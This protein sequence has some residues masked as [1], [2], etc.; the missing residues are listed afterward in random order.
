[1]RSF[2]YPCQGGSTARATAACSRRGWRASRLWSLGL[3]TLCALAQAQEQEGVDGPS[4]LEPGMACE[5]MSGTIGFEQQSVFGITPAQ[6]FAEVE[7]E[8]SARLEWSLPLFDRFLQIPG[9]ESKIDVD[10]RLDRSR[11]TQS[12]GMDCTRALEAAVEVSVA[13]VDGA[14]RGTYEGQIAYLDGWASRLMPIAIAVPD[15]ALPLEL[16]PGEEPIVLMEIDRLSDHCAGLIKVLV[17][18]KEEPVEVAGWGTA[19]WSSSG[20]PIG[21]RPLDRATREGRRDSVVAARALRY[22]DAIRGKWEDGS[23]TVLIVHSELAS[24]VMCE[25]T[26]FGHLRVPLRLSVET[27]DGR[28]LL[29][30]VQAE[31]MEQI[32]DAPSPTLFTTYASAEYP[33]GALP[34]AMPSASPCPPDSA[35]QITF[36]LNAS[37]RGRSSAWVALGGVTRAG[38]RFGDDTFSSS[39]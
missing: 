11:I 30:E 19:R 4:P 21:S 24:G 14:L 38:E 17:Q 34:Q 12:V 25:D 37:S 1:M 36:N 27:E 15:D 33:C 18:T 16:L 3:S 20:C 5:F 26:M 22:A 35:W 13:T 9:L 8:C 31:A 32:G 29:H 7:G 6:A 2:S 39:R 10:V 28:V 23:E